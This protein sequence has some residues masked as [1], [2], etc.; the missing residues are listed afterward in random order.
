MTCF[1][2]VPLRINLYC[3]SLGVLGSPCLGKILYHSLDSCAA[4]EGSVWTPF[5]LGSEL[6]S[7]RI[8]SKWSISLFLWDTF[9]LYSATNS[10]KY[11]VPN[12]EEGAS[13]CLFMLRAS[14]PFGVWGYVSRKASSKL[15][16]PRH[17]G[18]AEPLCLVVSHSDECAQASPE[19]QMRHLGPT[20]GG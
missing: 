13:P 7:N 10:V 19:V 6:P 16:W 12:I 14:E 2:E 11:L 1:V 9:L 17:S 4:R 5:T 18:P 8:Y 20:D 3:F 15:V